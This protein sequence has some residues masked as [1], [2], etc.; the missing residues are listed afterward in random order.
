MIEKFIWWIVLYRRDLES[1]LVKRILVDTVV[2]LGHS[3]SLR[4]QKDCL[5]KVVVGELR[6]VC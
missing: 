5:A 3:L 2:C 6:L 1:K 4:L